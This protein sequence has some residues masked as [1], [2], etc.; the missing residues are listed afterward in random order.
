MQG[1]DFFNRKKFA[2][3]FK[4]NFWEQFHCVAKN[5]KIRRFR[6]DYGVQK[7]PKNVK[8]EDITLSFLLQIEAYL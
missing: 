1:K 5:I 7:L 6:E 2:P 4:Q 3:K 8:R